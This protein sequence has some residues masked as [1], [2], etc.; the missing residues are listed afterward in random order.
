MK[1][2]FNVMMDII[3]NKVNVSKK[4]LQKIVFKLKNIFAKFVLLN[5]RISMEIVIRIKNFPIK[6]VLLEVY[7][8]QICVSVKKI[9]F[10]F[11]INALRKITVINT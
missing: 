1:V 2:V 9:F 7:M 3:W 11:K 4:N 10:I 5:L 6:I 8:I